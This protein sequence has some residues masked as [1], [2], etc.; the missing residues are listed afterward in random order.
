MMIDDWQTEQSGE[1]ERLMIDA[2]ID[3]AIAEETEDDSF[4]VPLFQ[5]KR[6]SRSEGRVGGGDSVTAPVISARMEQLNAPALP[7]EQPFVFPK[8]SAMHG[9]IAIPAASAWPIPRGP[10]MP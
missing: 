3:R 8:N 1:I 7:F 5:G 9:P 4:D 10:L 2:L 6:K